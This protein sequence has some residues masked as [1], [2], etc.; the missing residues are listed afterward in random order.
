[1]STVAVTK[2]GQVAFKCQ[3]SSVARSVRIDQM[4]SGSDPT[5]AKL[6]I[7]AVQWKEPYA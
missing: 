3:N 7:I 2:G 1:M 6:S 5:S 4:V